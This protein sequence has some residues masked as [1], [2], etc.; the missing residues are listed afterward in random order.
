MVNR[1]ISIT[2]NRFSGVGGY[3]EIGIDPGFYSQG[4]CA[5]LASTAHK[6]LA[7]ID[8][9]QLLD[10]GYHKLMDGEIGGGCTACVGIFAQTGHL[11]VAK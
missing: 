2:A 6:A 8:P 11:F 7:D 3:N 4:L 9:E 1:A 10:I 5:R